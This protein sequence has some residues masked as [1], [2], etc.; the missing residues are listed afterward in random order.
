V[1]VKGPLG[2]LSKKFKHVP[3]DMRKVK[4]ASTKKSKLIFQMWMQKRK[5]IAVLGTVRGIINNM[6]IGEL[7]ND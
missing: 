4:D 1:T 7:V 3:F 5:Q 6:I 2:K